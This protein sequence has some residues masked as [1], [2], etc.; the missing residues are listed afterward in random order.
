MGCACEEFVSVEEDSRAK[1]ANVPHWG[2]LIIGATVFCAI[3]LLFASMYRRQRI[4]GSSV[5]GGPLCGGMEL[6]YSYSSGYSP[7]FD[8]SSYTP[9]SISLF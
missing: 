2:A 1:Y 3:L 6:P 4:M 8:F 7:N 5:G 9:E